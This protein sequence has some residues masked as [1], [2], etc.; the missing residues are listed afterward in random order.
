[1]FSLA[2]FKYLDNFTNYKKH[3][4]V[5]HYYDRKNI[6]KLDDKNGCKNIRCTGKEM[7][8]ACVIN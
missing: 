4:S 1:M 2:T 7:S 5:F 6:K 3:I 8:H